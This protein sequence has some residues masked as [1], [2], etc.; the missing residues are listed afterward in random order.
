MPCSLELGVL[1]RRQPLSV[2]PKEPFRPFGFPDQTAAGKSRGRWTF[3]TTSTSALT[4]PRAILPDCRQSG[5]PCSKARASARR[6]RS[7]TPR[8][9]AAPRRVTLPPRAMLTAR[10]HPRGGRGLGGQ[11]VLDVLDFFVDSNKNEENAVFYKFPMPPPGGLTAARGPAG[12]DAAEVRGDVGRG[13]SA[14]ST[15][16][17]VGGQTW[18]RIGH[19]N[20]GEEAAT[21]AAAVRAQARDALDLRRRTAAAASAA[22]AR[23]RCGTTLCSAAGADRRRDGG[24][25][26]SCGLGVGL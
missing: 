6:S 12:P 26:A 21:A 17:H 13:A 5:R 1:A 2:R 10:W 18:S 8:C 23:H 11:A 25:L 24:S 22:I 19:W 14:L 16:T 7:R 9:V 15:E 3:G 20:A 4:R